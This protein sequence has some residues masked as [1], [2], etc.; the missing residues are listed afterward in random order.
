MSV[1]PPLGHEIAAP[2]MNDRFGGKLRCSDRQA[3]QG[4]QWAG[5]FH[6]AMDIPIHRVTQTKGIMMLLDTEIK[7]MVDMASERH[8]ELVLSIGP[9]ATYDTS[10]SVQTPEGSRMGYRLSY[11]FFGSSTME[12]LPSGSRDARF[13]GG[14]RIEKPLVTLR[15]ER[16]NDRPC[17]LCMT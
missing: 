6:A 5:R 15:T 9:R 7:A 8:L 4:P 11:G 12:G 3:G 17:Q 10:A 14:V 1:Q 2:S 16:E 13:G